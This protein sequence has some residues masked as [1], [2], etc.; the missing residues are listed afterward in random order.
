[1]FQS[2]CFIYFDPKVRVLVPLFSL[3][4]YGRYRFV[5]KIGP[6]FVSTEISVDI[7]ALEIIIILT[8]TGDRSVLGSVFIF[9][10]FGAS[11]KSESKSSKR[12]VYGAGA[13]FFFA[14]SRSRP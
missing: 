14:W 10:K 2:L 1:M 4:C 3:L 7:S 9:Y 13:G 12:Q 6:V 5:I 8:V 11:Q